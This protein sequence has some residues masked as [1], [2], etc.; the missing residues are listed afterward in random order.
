VLRLVTGEPRLAM[1]TLGGQTGVVGVVGRLN[2]KIMESIKQYASQVDDGR[3]VQQ[4][5]RDPL[6]RAQDFAFARWEEDCGVCL[7]G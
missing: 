5:S 3:T 1:T 2:W 7:G 4:R 6:V